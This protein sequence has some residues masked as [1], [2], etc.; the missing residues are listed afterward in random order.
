MNDAQ[1]ASLV[2]QNAKRAW[3]QCTWL[4]NGANGSSCVDTLGELT[5]FGLT[6]QL[7]RSLCLLHATTGL[8]PPS[9]EQLPMVSCR[10][11]GPG[12]M[13]RA[14]PPVQPER[15]AGSQANVLAG[16]LLRHF[17]ELHRAI[18]VG[19]PHSEHTT[20]SA[21]SSR[22]WVDPFTDARRGRRVSPTTRRSTP[23]QWRCSRSAHAERAARESVHLAGTRSRITD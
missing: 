22:R 5:W 6:E 11:R 3:R 10:A 8:P 18:E 14:P 21:G 7:G 15:A 13:C 12:S 20:S 4:R 9:A 23:P 16:L 19:R 1:L 17:P 2:V